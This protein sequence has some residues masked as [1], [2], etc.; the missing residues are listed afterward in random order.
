MQKVLGRDDIGYLAP[1]MAADF[2]VMDWNQLTYA[3]GCYDRWHV[4]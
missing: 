4:L 3:G 2:T 1:G